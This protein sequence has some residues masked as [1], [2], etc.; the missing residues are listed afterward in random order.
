[1]VDQIETERL[2]LRQFVLSDVD[3]FYELGTDP[4]IIRYVGNQPF[5]SLDM[6]REILISAPLNDYATRGFGRFACVWKA[7][8][9]VIG[10]CGPKF[11]PDLGDVE[12]GYRFL[13]RYWGM[14]LAT[15]SARAVIDYARDTLHLHRLIALV[16]Q[17]NVASARVLEKLGFS[18]ER[19]TTVSWFPNVILGL[20]SKRLGGTG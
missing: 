4:Q 6:A 20:H 9:E 16:H 19:T 13:P 12:L 14:G 1:M 15:E 7:T 17:D 5:A 2:I 10:F 3:S 8:G 18:V 11:L